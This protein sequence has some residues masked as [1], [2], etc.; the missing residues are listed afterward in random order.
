[1]D[2]GASAGAA[3]GP[4]PQLAIEQDE[5]DAWARKKTTATTNSYVSIFGAFVREVET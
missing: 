3:R 2:A 1:V 5:T 4:I